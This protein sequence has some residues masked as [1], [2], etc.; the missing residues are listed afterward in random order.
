MSVTWWKDIIFCRTSFCPN[1]QQVVIYRPLVVRRGNY[2]NIRFYFKTL[3][4]HNI[5]ILTH[6]ATVH[7]GWCVS[8]LLH[9]SSQIL[10]LHDMSY[11]WCV[12]LCSD[13]MLFPA[14]RSNMAAPSVQHAGVM[15]GEAVVEAAGVM[16]AAG[17]A[18]AAV[19][20]R[21]PQFGSRFLTDPRQVFQHNAWCVTTYPTQRGHHL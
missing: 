14:R 6:K 13:S 21:R 5:K 7:L 15:D 20:D 4:I 9:Y 1:V 8:S 2:T 18:E 3:I 19:E 16:E 10:V 17:V 11:L 12:I